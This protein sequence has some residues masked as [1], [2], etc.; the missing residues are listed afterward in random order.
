MIHIGL[1][2]IISKRVHIESLG[3][4]LGIKNAITPMLQ[5]RESRTCSWPQIG[6]SGDFYEI[7]GAEKLENG[8]DFVINIV[9]TG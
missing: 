9:F 7:K 4:K 3:A 8:T 2:S 1:S 6:P 5:F